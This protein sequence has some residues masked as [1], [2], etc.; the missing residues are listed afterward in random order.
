MVVLFD[1]QAIA[2]DAAAGAIGVGIASYAK[3]AYQLSQAGTGVARA[4]YLGGLGEDAIGATASR[5]GV[6]IGGRTVFPDVVGT[7]GFQ[8]AKNVA[9][10]GSRD[11]R[12]ISAYANFSAARGLDPVQVFTRPAT[13]ITRLQ[14]LIQA[15]LVEQKLLPGINNLGVFSITTGESALTGGGLG[16]L[17]NIPYT[18]SGK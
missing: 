13:D 18:S 12:Q 11:A 16:T 15:G 14:S 1:L 8:E 7:S 17:L 2:I 9:V 10:I 4:R 5:E 3:T 6:K